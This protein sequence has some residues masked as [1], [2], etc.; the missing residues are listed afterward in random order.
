MRCGFFSA[1][2]VLLIACPCTAIAEGIRIEHAA[3]KL[4]EDAY[5]LDATINFDFDGELLL[6]LEKGVELNIEV[7]V[8]VKRGRKW[9]W[10]P[11][12]A[13]ERMKFRL[14]HHPLSNDYIVTDLLNN[15]PHQFP[16]ADAAI[17]H[18]GS[19]SNHFL[20]DKDSI[21]DGPTYT[22]Y[23]R[24]RLNIDLLPAPLQPAAYVSREWRLQ[25]PW[26]DWVI[27]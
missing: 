9:L 26:Y 24:A 2:L 21:R 10:D 1:C 18:L 15:V 17:R 11:V 16:S 4:V 8:R 25:S 23:L 22:G 13:E 5:R 7:Q 27:Q 3:S 6:A 19:I 14:Q 20:V 12:V